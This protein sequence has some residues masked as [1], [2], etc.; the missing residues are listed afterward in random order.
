MSITLYTQQYNRHFQG[1]ISVSFYRLYTITSF[2]FYLSGYFLCVTEGSRE[3][4]LSIE[5][6]HE[7]I[8]AQ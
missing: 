4:V 7:F 3:S 5:H 6:M 8:E 2:F 1:I